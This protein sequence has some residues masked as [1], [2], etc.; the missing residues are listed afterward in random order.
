[1]VDADE[2]LTGSGDTIAFACQWVG[3]QAKISGPDPKVKP[4]NIGKVV[5]QR[6]GKY[7]RNLE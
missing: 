4:E 3:K 1:M 5:L 6:R 7:F 2:K